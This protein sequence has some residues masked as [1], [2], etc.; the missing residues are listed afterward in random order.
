MS[1]FDSIPRVDRNRFIDFDWEKRTRESDELFINQEGFWTFPDGGRLVTI[2]PDNP[3]VVI[4][5]D[6]PVKTHPDAKR[7]AYPSNLTE[8]LV[9]EHIKNHRREDFYLLGNVLEVS[10]DFHFLA[11]RRYEFRH[12]AP[13]FDLDGYLEEDVAWRLPHW[14]DDTHRGN[15]AFD[16]NR[17]LKLIDY[18]CSAILTSLGIEKQFL[19]K[20]Q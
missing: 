9:Y 17:G 1:L 4:K 14:I 16:E 20:I 15:F 6:C 8:Y 13:L 11:M 19:D 7:F 2:H 10:D 5:R 3:A 18:D 12:N